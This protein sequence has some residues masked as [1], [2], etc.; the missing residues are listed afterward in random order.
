VN[1]RHFIQRSNSAM[2]AGLIPQLADS[3]LLSRKQRIHIGAQTNAFG[4]PIK[5]FGRLL[6]VIAILSSLGYEGFETAVASLEAG[7]LQPARW[8]KEFE[9]RH[10]RLIAAHCGGP[11]YDKALAGRTIEKTRRIANYTVMMGASFLVF[12]SP[13]LRHVNGK[14]DLTSVR[15][16]AEGLNRVGELVQKEGLKLCFHNEWSEFVDHPS[17]ESFILND[18]DP[19]LVWLCFDIGNPYG[20][21][22]G[23]NPAAFSREH[24]RRIAT[25]HLKDAVVNAEGKLVTVPFGGGRINLKGVVAPLLRSNWEGWLTVEEEGIWPHGTKHPE[26]VLRQSREYLRR[27]TGV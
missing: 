5:P 16:T 10:I 7:A 13:R 12:T 20:H 9:A 6:E 2:L 27:T 19:R 24:F 11:L 23:W 22:P 8:G 21:V 3:A 18:T 25:Y 26:R 4:V 1:R 15:N 14:L 17:E